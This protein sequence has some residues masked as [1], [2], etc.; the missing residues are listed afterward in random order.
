VAVVTPLQNPTESRFARLHPKLYLALHAS[1]G[2][3]LAALCAW[4]FFV[5][6]DEVPEKG[7]MVL[8]DN[9]TTRWLQA[10]GTEM[11]E[12]VFVGISFIGAQVLGVVL[13]AIA[14]VLLIRRD[15]HRFMLLAITCAGGD[16]LNVALKASFHRTRPEYASEFHLTSW[17]FPSGHAMD[18]LIGFGLLA[19]WVARRY[20]KRRR[21]VWVAAAALVLL[22]GYARIYLGVHFLSDVVAGYAAGL[23]WLIVCISGSQFAEG[24]RIGMD[25]GR[26]HREVA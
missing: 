13:G 18:S 6:A 19:Y 10:H 15:L 1:I 14:I 5:L 7:W 11:G 17:S 3:V 24:R 21:T 25:P 22:I 20:P 9:A 26:T 12:T 8:I 23:V 4:L 2:F 16:L